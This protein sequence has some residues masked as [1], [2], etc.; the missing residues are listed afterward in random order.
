MKIP[1]LVAWLVAVVPLV[2]AAWWASFAAGLPEPWLERT[3][4][5]EITAV[6][7]FDEWA[8]VTAQPMHVVPR[9]VQ[10]AALHVPGATLGSVVWLNALLAIV[11]VAALAGLCRR[12]FP[13][14]AAGLPI[15]VLVCGL[16][17]ATPALGANWLHV[18]RHGLFLVPAM[19]VAALYWLHG[20]RFFAGRCLLA[21]AIAGLAPFCHAHGAVVFLA[22]VPAMLGAA[23]RAG[24]TRGV[25]WVGALLVVGN[26][27]AVKSYYGAAGV[28]VGGAD[29][30]GA[31]LEEPTRTLRT[32]LGAT[33]AAWLDPLPG[34]DL[35]D[36]ALGAFSWL[37]PVAA[38]WL[39]DRS[40]AARAA[41]APCWADRKSVV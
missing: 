38:W 13:E 40:P 37:L 29:W 35:D 36:V 11:L 34:T 33:G 22:L 12:A 26:V 16:L 41:A 14:T 28:G 18:E 8:E 17:V 24:S 5:G 23:R 1:R 21:L 10:L 20:T 7:S 39:G 2:A 27:A 25:A 32:L 9:V 31:L 6:W 30:F 3:A 15:V 19:F 4:L